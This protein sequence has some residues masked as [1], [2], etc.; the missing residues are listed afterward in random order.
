M[1]AD[2][3][4][5]VN[6]PGLV[7]TTPIMPHL[8]SN[9]LDPVALSN[10]IEKQIR[11]LIIQHRKV[12]IYIYINLFDNFIFS[13]RILVIQHNLMIIYHIY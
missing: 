2:A 8:M 10:D 11:A 4:A 12:C 7:L 6:T 3:I 9:I 5:S 13:I 1:S